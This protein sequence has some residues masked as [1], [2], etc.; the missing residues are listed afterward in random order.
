MG[1]GMIVSIHQPEHLPWLG[2]FHKMIMSD[3]FV[4]LDNVQYRKNY[5]QNRNRIRTKDGFVWLTVPVVSKGR[6]DQTI[7][8]VKI[9]NSR[10]WAQKHWKSICFNYSGSEYFGSFSGIL[11]EIYKRPWESLS[12]LNIEIIRKISGAVGIKSEMMVSSEM[13]VSGKSTDLLLDICKK[14][15]A[16]TY[17]SGRFGI[18]YLDESKFKKSGVAVKYHEFEHPEYKQVFE[19]FVPNM[20]AIDLIFNCGEKSLTILSKRI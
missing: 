14:L 9:D 1:Y 13:G 20:S 6:S 8:E 17:L 18:E 5:F 15:D 2:F 11:S 7:R 12:E 16:D 4:L 10:R 19:P 3:V